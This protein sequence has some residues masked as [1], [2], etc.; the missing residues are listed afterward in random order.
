MQNPLYVVCMFS[1]IAYLISAMFG[2]SMYYTSPY[3]FVILGFLFKE[4]VETQNQKDNK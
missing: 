4:I 1:V 3:Y 2:N